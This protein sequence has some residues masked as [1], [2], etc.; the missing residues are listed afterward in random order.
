MSYQL[1]VTKHVITIQEDLNPFF[2]NSAQNIFFNFAESLLIWSKE[3]FID[4]DLFL[5]ID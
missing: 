3:I 2:E 1:P 5:D 4:R